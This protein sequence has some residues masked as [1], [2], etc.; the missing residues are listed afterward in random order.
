MNGDARLK[1]GVLIVAITV[2]LAL[3]IAIGVATYLGYRYV[4][5]ERMVSVDR[6]GKA[7]A[8]VVAA[9]LFG[10]SD[11]RVGRLSGT[12]QGTAVSSRLWGWLNAT[13][14]VKAPFEVNYFVNVSQL[15][16]RDFVMNDAGDRIVITVP[17]VTIERPNVD[18]ARASLNDVQG[19]FVSRGAMVEM[20]SKV[21]ASA[22]RAASDRANSLENRAK[23]RDYARAAVERLFTGALRAARVDA[24]VS[25]RFAGDPLPSGE[26]WDVSRSLE[27]VLGTNR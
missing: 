1:S 16:P 13:Q 18:L 7:T 24:Q 27:E 22:Q 19:A 4:T 17:D 23:A 11:L 26:R 21:A 15:G 12:V 3:T 10:R 20:G 8:Q 2:G 14:V 9:T 25:V 5:D 6:D